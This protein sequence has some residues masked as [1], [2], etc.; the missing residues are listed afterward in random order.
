MYS[1][2]S[3]DLLRESD[4][5]KQNTTVK[6]YDL[7]DLE[8]IVSLKSE[9]IVSMKSKMSREANGKLQMLSP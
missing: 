6:R 3:Q 9:Q 5:L 2:N 4:V 1:S 7:L 8:Q